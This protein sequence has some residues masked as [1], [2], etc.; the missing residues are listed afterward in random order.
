MLLSIDIPIHDLKKEERKS[1]RKT[2][3]EGN[4]LNLIEN[5]YKNPIANIIHNGER[6]DAFLLRRGT[7]K[8]CPPSPTLI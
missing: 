6:L 7:R 5:I 1:L 8:E 4:Y 2:E 3:I